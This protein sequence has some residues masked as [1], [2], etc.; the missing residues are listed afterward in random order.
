MVHHSG[1]THGYVDK[2]DSGERGLN[3]W[4]LN[5]FQY[6]HVVDNLAFSSPVF[7]KGMRVLFLIKPKLGV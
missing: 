6:V 3:V 5:L 1:N 7:V 4:L 2:S